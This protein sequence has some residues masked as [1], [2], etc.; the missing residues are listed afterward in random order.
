MIDIESINKIIELTK[1]GE[2]VQAETLYKELVEKNPQD[3]TLLSAFGLFYVNLGQYDNAVVYLK[4]ACEINKTAGNVSALGFVEYEKGNYFEAAKILE[5][6]LTYGE[7]AEIYNKLISCLFEIKDYTRAIDFSALMHQKYPNNPNSIANMVKSLTQS[8][9]LQEAEVLCV[10]YL[11]EHNDAA[12]LWIHLGFLKELIYC[13]DVQA[14][15]CFQLAYDLGRKD[16]LYNIAVSLQKQGKLKEAENTYQEMLKLFPNNLSATTSLGMCL[17]KQKKFEEGY[18]LYFQRARTSLTKKSNNP[19]TPDKNF[20]KEVVVICDQGYGDHIQFI[21]YLPYLKEKAEKVYVACR[22]S[23][24]ELFKDNYPE[25]DFI[26]F[27]EINPEMQS[28]R[29][30]DLAFALGLDFDHIPYSAGYLNTEK[31]EIKSDKLKVGLC[32]EAGSAAIRTMINRTINIKLLEPFLNLETVQVYSFQV[33]DSLGGN[34]IYPQMI[35]LAKD[36]ANFKDTAKA[37][38]SMDLVITVDTALAHLAGACGVKTF[39]ML[40]YSSDW[41]WFEDN[42]TTPWYDSIEIFKQTDCISWEKPIEDILCRLK[43]YSL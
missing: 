34:K 27:D 31:A 17:L 15:K 6:A 5:E 9:K 16:A 14:C 36:F 7:S 12:G 2:I 11:K 22:E 4:R 30:T 3:D 43:E 41:R 21:R 37:L 39:L 20:E 29:I 8:G 28:I 24:Y 18:K 38:K 35:N 26:T 19:W 23:L 13:D 32:W 10:N 25:I 40:P 1:Q 33:E 42:K